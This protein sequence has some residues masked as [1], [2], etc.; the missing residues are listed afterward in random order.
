MTNAQAVATGGASA[1]GGGRRR[2]LWKSPVLIAA[3]VVMATLL[4][5]RMTEGWHW[6]PGAFVVVGVLVCTVAFVYQLVT[7]HSDSIAYRAAAGMVFVGGFI[8]FWGNVVQ[9]VDGNPNAI[10]YFVTPLVGI[11]G[12]AVARLRPD[13][14][15][16]ASFVTAMVQFIALAAVGI[17]LVQNAEISSWPAPLWRGFVGN[18]VFGVL[19]VVA[20]L[21]FRKAGRDTI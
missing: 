9:R 20:G 4:A 3:S 8:T 16:R 10:L 12:A 21:L 15:A 5:S 1:G 17:M 2:S 19:L 7:R 14:M 6:R 18:G 11:C 13:G